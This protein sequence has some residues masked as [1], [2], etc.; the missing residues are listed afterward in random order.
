MQAFSSDLTLCICSKPHTYCFCHYVIIAFFVDDAVAVGVPRMHCICSSF[1]PLIHE[2]SSSRASFTTRLIAIHLSSGIAPIKPFLTV[3]F[4]GWR[5][6]SLQPAWTQ[7]LI[8]LDSWCLCTCPS[9]PLPW[10][11]LRLWFFP[12][13]VSTQPMFYTCLLT[14]W[15]NK[16]MSY[17]A[18]CI[19]KI[20]EPEEPPKIIP[21]HSF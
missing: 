15:K 10:D 7:A 20:L 1:R 16:W 19:S 13:V 3:H 21:L 14:E 4:P 17:R 2:A 18:L 5:R 6:A 12:P 8:T 11:S 9:L